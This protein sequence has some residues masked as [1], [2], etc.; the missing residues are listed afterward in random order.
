[1]GRAQGGFLIFGGDGGEGGRQEIRRES[2]MG[3]RAP[4]N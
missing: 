4:G 2:G 1:M 3:E